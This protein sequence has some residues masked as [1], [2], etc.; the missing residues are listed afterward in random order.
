MMVKP[1]FS[2]DF[3]GYPEKRAFLFSGICNANSS[4]L[5]RLVDL[6]IWRFGDLVIL[7]V[8]GQ[9]ALKPRVLVD[10]S[11]RQDWGSV[12]DTVD[13]P[14]QVDRCLCRS[15]GSLNATEVKTPRGLDADTRERQ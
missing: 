14:P 7:T 10:Q 5:N 13:C 12:A 11:N 3:E 8:I 1:N 6:E 2:V 9:Q 4:E 15:W